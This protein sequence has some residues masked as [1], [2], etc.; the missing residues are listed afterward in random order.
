MAFLILDSS[1]LPGDIVERIAREVHHANLATVLSGVNSEL[2]KALSET[3][4]SLIP[5]L[6]K[7]FP[8]MILGGGS[9]METYSM[10]LYSL[11]RHHFIVYIHNFANGMHS[12]VEGHVRNTDV[13]IVAAYGDEVDTSMFLPYFERYVFRKKLLIT[14][15]PAPQRISV[16]WDALMRNHLWRAQPLR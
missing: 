5:Y 11:T 14:H 7:M 15:M 3:R 4:S 10:T 12:L 9:F 8:T 16:N 13:D 2:R 1:N 6:R